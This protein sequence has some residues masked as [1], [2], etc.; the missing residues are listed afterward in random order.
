MYEEKK[1]KKRLI[2]LYKLQVKVFYNLFSVEARKRGQFH[3]Y[4][5]FFNMFSCCWWW[6]NHWAISDSVTPWTVASQAPLS[7][8]FP[9]Q[10]YWSGLTFP[11][12]EKE[13][14]LIQWLSLCFLHCNR[15]SEL[16][17][18]SLQLSHQLLSVAKWYLTLCDPMDCSTPGFTIS[19]SLLKLMSFELVMPSNH[20]I[21]CRLLLLLPSILLS[22]RVFS[23]WVMVEF[24]QNM[25]H[26]R[27]NGKPLQYS[28][29]ENPMNIMKMSHQGVVQI[30]ISTMDLRWFNRVSSKSK[31]VTVFWS[32][33]MALQ[34][35]TL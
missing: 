8:G 31:R 34:N 12:P 20:L 11:S 19:Q 30:F 2:R 18:D 4:L 23:K 15:P 5:N 27:G 25:N 16:Q 7:M 35:F 21:L 22:I 13:S 9:R 28:C 24:S 33:S 6:F 29:L 3:N 32:I 10:E 1:K 26:W 17:A 14:F